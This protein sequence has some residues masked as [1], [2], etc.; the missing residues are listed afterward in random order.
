M[1]PVTESD[2]HDTPGFVHQP[3]PS[4]A[5]VI[6]DSLMGG[7]DPVRQ[8]V[9]TQE[10]PH[11]LHR[12]EFRRPRRQRPQREVR[13]DLEPTR[14]MPTGLI[15]Q[16]HRMRA[17][18]HLAR[19][20]GQVQAHVLTRATGQNQARALALSRAD[21]AEDIGRGGPLVL[22]RWGTAAAPGPAPRDL[23]LLPDP[24]LIGEPDLY[25]LAAGLITRDRRQTGRKLFLK[26]ATAAS[27]LAWWRGR[28]ESLREPRARTSR[29]IVCWEMEMRNSSKTHWTRSTRR[30]RTTP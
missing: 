14:L 20:L 26:T 17:G 25:G 6:D 21:R 1:G 5:A 10:L 8:P 30:Q 16:H 9:V 18:R 11:V 29:L 22:R 3:V 15:E 24:G 2:G 23:V 28:A 12:I 19:D 7:E 4:P 13:R 27:L